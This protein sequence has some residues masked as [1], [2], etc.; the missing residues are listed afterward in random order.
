MS[1]KNIEVT[2]Q[3][4]QHR[5]VITVDGEEAGF[6]EYAP[7]KDAHGNDIRDFNHTVVDSAFRGQGLSKP[8][9]A[10]ALDMTRAE[11]TQIRATCSAVEGFVEKNPD[12][13]DLVVK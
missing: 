8:L 11:G 1:G 5:F 12:Y 7:A 10:H 6:A 9:I 2:H 4:D 13:A 3:Q